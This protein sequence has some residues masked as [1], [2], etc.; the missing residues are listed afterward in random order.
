M[1]KY[2]CVFSLTMVTVFG[3]CCIPEASAQTW[4]SVIEQRL[5]KYGHRNWIVIADAAYPSQSAD[6]IETV[7]TGAGQLEVLQHVLK[8]IDSASHIRPVVLVDE[9]LQ[10]VPERNAAG[11][12]AYREQLDQIFDDRSV[13]VMP[14]DEIIG[15]LDKGSQLFNVLILKTKMTIPYTSVFIELDCGYW[16]AESEQQLRE[17]IKDRKQKE[18]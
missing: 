16:D 7:A 12:E 2:S 6:G 8:K 4:K 18:K 1:N 3:L 9:E 10:D 5:P 17:K 11:V 15:K 14:H 13:K